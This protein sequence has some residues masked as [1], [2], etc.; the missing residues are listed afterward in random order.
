MASPRC[1]DLIVSRVLFYSTSNM[2]L[3]TKELLDTKSTKKRTKQGKWRIFCE[4]INKEQGEKESAYFTFGVSYIL[5][6]L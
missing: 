1:R 5:L 3:K 4:W 2:E 6:R